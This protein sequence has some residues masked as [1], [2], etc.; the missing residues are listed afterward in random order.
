[1]TELNCVQVRDDLKGY[2]DQNDELLVAELSGTAAWMGFN[3]SG[4]DW[5]K[6]NL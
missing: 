1:V 6:K 5:L 3:K 4:S 2:I